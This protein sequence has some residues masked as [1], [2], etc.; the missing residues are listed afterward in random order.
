MYSLIIHLLHIYK[1]SWEEEVVKIVHSEKISPIL[2]KGKDSLSVMYLGY[3]DDEPKPSSETSGLLLLT[4][5]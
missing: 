3:S 4:P 5:K 2:I 1:S